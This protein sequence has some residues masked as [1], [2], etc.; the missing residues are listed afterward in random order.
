MFF[1]VRFEV[2]DHLFGTLLAKYLV[3]HNDYGS[4][5]AGPDTIH[6]LQ[7]K[8]HISRRL[9]ITFELQL[10]FELGNYL[11]CAFDMTNG[12]AADGY[13]VFAA[14]GEMELGVE[15]DDTVEF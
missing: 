14:W 10:V 4:N 15:G 9:L 8:K 3:V 13:N 12:A 5:A 6:F 2:L 11:G 7:R 1:L